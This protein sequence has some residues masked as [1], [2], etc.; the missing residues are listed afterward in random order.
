[1][2]IR[3]A[4]RLAGA[5]ALLA[6]AFSAT[7]QYPSRPIRVV[8]PYA[9]G[10]AVDIL[11]RTIAAKVSEI[12][13]QQLTVDNRPGAGGNIGTE[14]MIRAPAD[15]Y[16]LLVHGSALV[17]NPHLYK[18]LPYDFER[19]LT[20]VAKIGEINNVVIVNPG[21]GVSNVRELIALA[22]GKPKQVAYGAAS[23]TPLHLAGEL[24]NELAQVDL[25][26]VPYKGSG[27]ALIDLMGGR[28][29]LMFDNAPS[30]LPH[31]RSGK[32]KA[33]AVTGSR[34]SA[35]LPELPT[36]VESGL[37]GF[38][39]TSWFAVFMRTNTAGDLAAR[40]QSEF[41][42]ALDAADLRTKL[43]EQGVE[44]TPMRPE[45]FRVFMRSEHERWGRVIKK[46]G[47]TAE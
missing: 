6:F 26:F 38:D 44:T 28:L 35:L 2:K 33:I 7:A 3:F 32:L 24:F 9:T 22:K 36:V 34:R 11:A 17:I 46:V 8:V 25:L 10:G 4:Y 19:D 16:T 29:Q 5:L 14:A 15:G 31:I 40:L 13:G 42:R 18:K 1:M 47:I 30:A 23:G 12:M 39:V 41:A 37:A 27:P 45:Q 43:T 21:I 20:P